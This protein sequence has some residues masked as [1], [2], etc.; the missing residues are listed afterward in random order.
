MKINRNKDLEQVIIGS[1]LSKKDS[2]EYSMK[3]LKKEYFYFTNHQLI[4]EA[5][6][7]VFL[8]DGS[9][10]IISIGNELKKENHFEKIGKNSYLADCV[11]NSFD[12][13]NIK[14]QIKILTDLYRLRTFQE[15]LQNSLYKIDSGDYKNTNNLISEFNKKLFD[16]SA[17]LI[18]EKVDIKS[19]INS[20]SK[21]QE[22]YSIQ[23][24]EGKKYLGIPTGYN[25]LDK[26]CEGYNPEHL[27]SFS[28]YTNVGK[29]TLMINMIKKLL[30]QD[31]NVC[32]FSLEMSQEDLFG[33]LLAV[34]TGIPKKKILK[35]LTDNE[36]F[37]K[38]E[39]A[40]RRLAKKNLVIYSQLSNIEEIVM[41][42]QTEKIKNKTD[43]FFL[44]YIQNIS[45]E[46]NTNEYTLLTYGI[47]L[48]QQTNRRIKSTLV[49][50]SQI[51]NET[52]KA[53]TELNVEGKGTGAIKAASDL[54]VFMKRDGTEEEINNCIENGLD[55]PIKII[56]N[57]NRHDYFGSFRLNHKL[58]TGE[59]Y[60]PI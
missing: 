8:E 39:E 23:N 60:E 33:K 58:S 22:E 46:E 19:I 50:L 55:L 5:C 32:V 15:T 45:S 42:M 34:E 53:T 38:Q 35:N 54:F 47:K 7:T 24:E 3:N 4:F 51:S 12:N 10:D 30:D 59:M 1:L 57:K 6:S 17:E 26:M 9:I 52:N 14:P 36:I 56:V 31:K 2:F 37:A 29:T 21:R 48:L 40:K 43:V 25:S 18:E 13:F 41:A 20:F 16:I 11:K 44:D 49:L 28:A 27:M